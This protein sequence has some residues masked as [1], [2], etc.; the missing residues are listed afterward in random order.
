MNDE[1]KKD[2]AVGIVTVGTT[3]LA[4]AAG[5]VVPATVLAG[6]AAL[7]TVL[8][9]SFKGR[10][11]RRATKLFERMAQADDNPE[12]FVAAI[13]ERVQAQ[14]EEMLTKLRALIT[15]DLASVSADAQVPIARLG[16][17]YVRG[18]AV[19]WAARGWV[20]LLSE[21]TGAELDVLHELAG[22]AQRFR[23]ANMYE[24]REIGLPVGDVGVTLLLHTPPDEAPPDQ[25][26]SI[27]VQA[28]IAVEAPAVPC[29]DASRMFALLLQH[30]V[31]TDREDLVY[32]ARRNEPRRRMSARPAFSRVESEPPQPA[33]HLFPASADALALA[34]GVTRGDGDRP[35]ST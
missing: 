6:I 29:A 12:D 20:R 8:W 35:I 1:V 7:F 4:A 2:A 22:M 21:A 34:F 9:S 10:D 25:V 19:A 28:S 14:D 5:G 32:S 31:A 33:L 30:G 27:S 15:A 24:A 17:A 3:T 11:E 23:D 16:H 18:K 26:E 13:D